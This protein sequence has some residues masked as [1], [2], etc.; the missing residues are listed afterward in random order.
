MSL[1]A[2]PIDSGTSRRCGLARVGVDLVE[3]GGF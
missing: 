2:W 1:S 3:E